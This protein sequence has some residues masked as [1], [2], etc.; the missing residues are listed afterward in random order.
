[1]DKLSGIAQDYLESIEIL[2]E[3]RL[4]LE[5]ELREWWKVLVNDKILPE[6]KNDPI[7]DNLWNNQ[8]SPGWLELKTK[9]KLK[10]FL[11]IR[12]PRQIGTRHYLIEI[13][14]KIP[15]VNKLHKDEAVVQMLEGMQ[16]SLGC[17]EFF[18]L[19]CRV[20]FLT[21]DI[22]G[23][24]PDKTLHSVLDAAKKLYHVIRKIDTL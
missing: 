4:M 13:I 17:E 15:D 22:H 20:A 10:L 14:G 8:S 24:E 21:V 12:D 7:H 18:D 2:R 11:R 1:M 16:K 23:D 6:F 9:S 19:D 3:A 5:D